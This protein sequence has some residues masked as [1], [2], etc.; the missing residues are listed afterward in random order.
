MTNQKKK[1]TILAE[2]A[3]LTALAV[4]L[5]MI[6]IYDAPLGGSVTLFSM[7]PILIAASRHGSAWG[8]GTAFVYSVTQ[9]LLGISSV[10]WVPTP[11][12]ILL[13]CLFD[14]IIAFSLLGMPGLPVFRR[15]K[16]PG[17]MI[18]GALACILRFVSHFFCGAVV[19]YSITLEGQ[20]NDLVMEL[21]MWSYSFVYNITYMGP[22]I[23]ITLIA[24]P[25]LYGVLK[26]R[27]A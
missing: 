4:V 20:W 19:W 16:L 2:C 7:V 6:K 14:Y 15:N 26:R 11:G 21:G 8:F 9:L 18:G 1:T 27:R 24:L 23:V 17:L 22:E 25:I 5:S 10:A 3:I 13:C 12:G